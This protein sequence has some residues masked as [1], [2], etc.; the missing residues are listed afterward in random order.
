MADTVGVPKFKPKKSKILK[1]SMG[2]GV[3]GLAGVA[4]KE[5]DIGLPT[6]GNLLGDLVGYSL[7]GKGIEKAGSTVKKKAL[8]QKAIQKLI[9]EK[10]GKGLLKKLATGLIP[11]MGAVGAGLALHDVLDVGKLLVSDAAARNFGEKDAEGKGPFKSAAHARSVIPPAI[12]ENL[13]IIMGDVRKST[14]KRMAKNKK[15]VFKKNK[16]DILKSIGRKK[17]GKVGRPKGVGCAIRGHGKAMKRG[18]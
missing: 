11:G 10:A 3:G 15:Q 18:K 5:L 4:A 9:K 12:I 7:A 8:Q 17:G 16:K 1:T 14:K 6:T 13:G 2:L